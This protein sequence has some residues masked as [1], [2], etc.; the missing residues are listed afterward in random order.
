MAK[1]FYKILGIDKS[2]SEEE[3][4]KA[5]YKLAH[6]YHPDKGGGDEQKFKEINEAYQTLSNK[7]KRAQYDRFGTTFNNASQ[8]GFGAN[9]NWEDFSNFSNINMD[10]IF[11]IFGDTFF[12]FERNKPED[13]R[14]GNDI[15]VL[16]EV[17]L[18]SVI[19][20]QQTEILLKKG[21]KCTRCEGT[22][23]EPGTK[24]KECFTCR[25]T[26]RVQ[27]MRKT[28]F[29]TFTQ[30]AVCPECQGEGV[31]PEKFCNV[32]KGEGRVISEEKVLVNIPAGVDNN[33]VIKLKGKGE[34]GRRG[35]T[36][37][38]LYVRIVVRKHPAFKRKGDNVFIQKEISF[39][40]AVLGDKIKIPSLEKEELVVKI[41][42]GTESGKMLKISKRGIPHFGRMGRG[43][44]FIEFKIKTP[45]K[46]TKEQKELIEKLKK[47]GL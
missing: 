44:L 15:E 36:P 2:A 40:E 24:V 12:G 27:Q 28:I 46:L 37:G 10:D 21:S 18:E 22:G 30:H 38:D 6:K 3:I 41:P 4:K 7:E 31:K 39:S 8:Q 45:Q 20:N 29:G 35:G 13:L 33:Q 14:K 17:S 16:L 47:Q 25:G 32:C 26:G 23:A 43:D 34:A 19:K 9:V 42:A 11:D 1:D 5:Y